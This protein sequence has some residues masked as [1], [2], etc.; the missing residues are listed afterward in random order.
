MAYSLLI[1]IRILKARYITPKTNKATTL[2]S[3]GSLTTESRCKMPVNKSKPDAK[4][5]IVF[6]LVF[7]CFALQITK[8]FY[9]YYCNN[10]LNFIAYN[11]IFS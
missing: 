3:P 7:L 9:R 4:Y 8:Y 2:A 1:K 10:L 11:I 5:R 6:I